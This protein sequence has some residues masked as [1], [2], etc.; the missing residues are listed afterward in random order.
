MKIL[1]DANVL[2]PPTLRDLILCLSQRGIVQPYW[3]EKI[4]EEWTINVSRQL[5]QPQKKILK[6]VQVQMAE[7]FPDALV[8]NYDHLIETIQL[9]DSNDRHVSAAAI[10]S[11]VDILLTFN[12]KDFP[13][14][15]LRK[16]NISPLHP[17]RFFCDLIPKC[18]HDFISAIDTMVKLPRYLSST[19]SSIIESLHNRGLIKSMRMLKSLLK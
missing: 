13:K 11:K 18:G 15:G 7:Q 2:Y 5:S 19:P 8:K 10:H 6:E 3:S 1:L 17:D 16:Y 4:I 9:N 14:S 12:T